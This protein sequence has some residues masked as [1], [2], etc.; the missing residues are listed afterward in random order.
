[1][2]TE[3]LL[4]NELDIK[5]LSS[6]RQDNYLIMTIIYCQLSSL[7]GG[8]Y[9]ISVFE[10]Y[11]DITGKSYNDAS[12]FV[13]NCVYQVTKNF[14]YIV[15]VFQQ[16]LIAWRWTRLPRIIQAILLMSYAHYY[17]LPNEPKT[18]A[19]VI[20]IAIKLTKIYYGDKENA[21]FVN[22]IL[23]KVLL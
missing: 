21:K 17:Y 18:K 8:K 20:E 4:I 6:R 10:I 1:M 5:D 7:Y 2:E 13:Q 3:E 23:D 22:A 14:S 16:E 12:T 11:E 15:N 9:P 19:I